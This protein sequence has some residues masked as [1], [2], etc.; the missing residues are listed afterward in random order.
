M[1]VESRRTRMMWEG[2]VEGVTVRRKLQR[3]TYWGTYKKDPNDVD[4]YCRRC[5]PVRWCDPRSKEPG[6][7]RHVGGPLLSL[8]GKPL[9]VG[10]QTNLGPNRTI[11]S[12]QI[13]DVGL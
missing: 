11:K 2:E 3:K 13:I 4:V 9:G 7:K 12:N 8:Q 5:G 10:N 1:V 6:P